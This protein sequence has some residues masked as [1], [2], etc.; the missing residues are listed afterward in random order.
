MHPGCLR[1]KAEGIV[2]SSSASGRGTLRL[3]AAL[4]NIRNGSPHGSPGSTELGLS[5]MME[6]EMRKIAIVVASALASQCF[7]PLR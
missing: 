1:K 2:G 3:I 6:I 7:P 5:S 4:S